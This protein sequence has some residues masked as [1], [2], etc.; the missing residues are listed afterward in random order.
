V[1]SKEVPPLR[2]SP[3]NKNAAGDAETTS[4][5]KG[6]KPH[7][8]ALPNKTN[9][10]TEDGHNDAEV[11]DVG[12]DPPSTGDPQEIDIQNNS[13]S[14]SENGS[15]P[16]E[17]Y[18]DTTEQ[19]GALSTNNIIQTHDSLLARTDSIII[20]LTQNGEPCND[21]AHL[22]A[23]DD[24]APIIRNATPGKAKIIKQGCKYLIALIVE[25]G[26]AVILEEKILKEALRSLYDVTL[27]LQLRTIAISKTDVG[28]VSWDIIE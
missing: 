10:D 13:D 7:M 8:S 9:S 23:K 6:T 12:P 24:R 18:P 16:E 4:R 3:R 26:V 27:E 1:D 22:L 17:P 5:T 14:E 25:T 19:A 2:R 11:P 28:N 15:I 20:F 21:G